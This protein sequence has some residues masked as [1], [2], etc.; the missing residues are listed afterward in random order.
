VSRTARFILPVALVSLLAAGAARAR[1]QANREVQAAGDWAAAT[2]QWVAAVQADP[3][4][5]FTASASLGR[6]P[7][8]ARDDVLGILLGARGDSASRLLAADL[9]AGWG[10]ADEAWP[11]LD[12]NLPAEPAVAAALLRRFVDRAAGTR[13]RQGS[14]V[15]A[16][17]LE[18]LASL[19]EQGQAARVR[20]EAAQVYAD[21]GD[22]ASAQRL[23]D[24]MASPQE[25][26][27]AMAPAL[28]SMIRALARSGSPEQ[29]ERRLAAW[30]DRLG[31]DEREDLRGAIAWAWVAR[32]ELGRAE[33]I[34]APDSGLEA[35]EVR[36][37]IALYR[38]DLAQAR[39]LLAAA[40]PYTGS[41]EDATRRMAVLV[42]LE[43][44]QADRLPEFGR[45]MQELARG[46]TVPAVAGLRS[47]AERLAPSGGRADLLGFA[48]ELALAHRDYQSAEELLAASLAADSA[49]PH[50][51]AAE[52]AL[53]QVAAETGRTE[54]AMRRL[55]HLILSYP[56]SAVLPRARRL[57][58]RL[59]GAVPQ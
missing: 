29:A 56:Q 32:G 54:L 57:A 24:R 4:L 51:P 44:V 6:A 28:A 7:R 30:A 15:R 25:L 10:R 38:G 46:D 34:L 17:A 49:G 14:L 53:A 52:L 3:G 59:R 48:G 21:A 16:Y 43:R 11:L 9:L 22:L 18:R 31:S 42:L 55:E 20:L 40:G 37:W 12:A 58:D 45:A 47:A 26:G 8:A 36:G 39:A 35:G 23:L 19:A 5:L 27:S 13:S 33:A 41:R 50:A 2:R 1:A